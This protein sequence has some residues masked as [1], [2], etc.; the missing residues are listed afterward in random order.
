MTAHLPKSSAAL[1]QWLALTPLEL[2]WLCNAKR[3]EAANGHYRYRK[4]AKRDGTWRILAVPKSRLLRAQQKIFR[5]FIRPYAQPHPA[6]FGFV[7]GKSVIEHARTH[8]GARW[9]LK[10]DLKNFF[11]SIPLARVRAQFSRMSHTSELAQA[12][13][14]LCTHRMPVQL[15]APLDPFARATHRARQLPQGAPTSPMLANLVA[16]ALD[17][18]LTGLAAKFSLRYSRYADDLAFS[19]Q[20]GAVS[21]SPHHVATIIERIIRAEGFVH[22]A[23]KRAIVGAKSQLSITGIVVN[24]RV[25]MA[26]KDFDLLKAKVHRYRQN[27]EHCPRTY[28][29]LLGQI[30]WLRQLNP[31]KAAKLLAKLQGVEATGFPPKARENDELSHPRSL[32]TN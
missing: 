15:L 6:A 9:L 10:M 30:S 21:A 32:V 19:P 28:A 1:A 13:A 22:N 11:D 4:I 29:Q 17:Q 23:A 24:E 20:P 18:R 7:Q 27:L 8:V 5:E 26:R 3:V 31:Q 12:L 14:Q 25:N 2:N 16:Y